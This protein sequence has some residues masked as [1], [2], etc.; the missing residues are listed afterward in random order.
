[1]VANVIDDGLSTLNAVNDTIWDT[2]FLQEVNNKLGSVGDT[3]GG[4]DEESVSSSDG[5]G[6]H[7]E[8]DHSGEVVGGN[9]GANTEGSSV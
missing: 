2:G 8:W 6:V 5:H 4:L 1:M 9:T 3:F 7:P